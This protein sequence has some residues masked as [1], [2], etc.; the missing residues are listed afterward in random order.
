[1]LVLNESSKSASAKSINICFSYVT[2]A[3]MASPLSCEYVKIRAVKRDPMGNLKY[4]KF[5][6]SNNIFWG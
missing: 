2:L 6:P 4:R 3:S 1:M 5:N